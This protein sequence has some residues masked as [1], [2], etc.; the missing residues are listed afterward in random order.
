MAPG[1]PPF[2]KKYWLP[3]LLFAVGLFFQLVV[4]PSS[5]P[6]THYDVLK[7]G[8]YAS[9]EE[10]RKSYEQFS[11]K[12]YF[13]IYRSLLKLQLWLL[14]F[15]SQFL[16]RYAFE[17][18]SNP[19]LKKYYDLF[20][21]DEQQDVFVSIKKQYQNEED[22]TKIKLP[23]LD[24]SSYDSTIDAFNVIGHEELMS[25]ADR[26]KP[27]LVQVYSNWSPRCAQFSDSWK[28]I[29]SLLDGLADTGMV[30]ISDVELAAHHADNK[31]AKQPFFRNGLPALV[32]YPPFCRSSDCYMRYQGEL[33]V[34]AVIDW[35]A[36][37]V[38]GLPRILYYSKETLDYA[39][40]LFFTYLFINISVC[41]EKKVKILFFSSTGERA[42]PFLR[43]LAL[44]YSNYVAF[45]NI[46]WTEEDSQFWWNS[47]R[48][49]SA[50][51]FVLLKGSV[52]D[53]AV[54]HGLPNRSELIKLIEDHR[55]QEI[56]QLRSDTATQL[57]CDAKGHSRAGFD[58]LVWYCVIVAGRPS[59]ELSK[60]RELMH[61]TRKKLTGY[62]GADQTE[63]LDS[64][65]DVATSPAAIAFKDNR[66]SFAWLDGDV[67]KKLCLFYLNP[68]DAEGACGPRYGD[69]ESPRVFIVRFQRRTK[70]E[71]EKIQEKTK[72]NVMQSLLQQGAN[73]A[74]LLVAKYNGTQEADEIVKWIS[75][76]IK[77]GDTHAI[78][79]FDQKVPDLE[80]EEPSR[81]WSSGTR[82]V[83]SAGSGLV[84]RVKSVI[85]LVSDYAGDPRIGPS[86]LLCACISFGAIWLKNTSPSVQSSDNRQENKTK[87]NEM[88]GK[89]RSRKPRSGLTDNPVSITD[90]VPEDAVNL[91]S[92]G[93]DSE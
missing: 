87:T 23:L 80:L 65:N 16:I 64:L 25:G 21:L 81:V 55:R 2:L 56:P 41:C 24:P 33:S 82:T 71:E 19:I 77:D 1:I 84:Q 57:G 11:Q 63:N 48:V 4:L 40:F 50:P 31:F 7:L 72:N 26:E 69:H 32:A 9:V 3:L 27:L 54:Y 38:L 20:G 6:P 12:W 92:S 10:V 45:A 46:L 73:S 90:E 51:A 39:M 67:Q 76:I 85:S 15:R 49:E 68:E 17:L 60:M 13:Y 36:T 61:S 79:F 18:L 43:K 34:D 14:S 70:E 52:T 30:E 42:A 22:Y 37:Y 5:Y 83:H 62:A 78:P 88:T 86:L 93:S 29:A 53:P 58:T 74:S 75:Q 47:L 89:R 59:S 28:R 66:L 91:L 35:T 8:R 44:E